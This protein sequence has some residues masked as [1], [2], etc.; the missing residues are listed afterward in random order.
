MEF[1][2]GQ[3]KKKDNFS[4]IIRLFWEIS[5]H[6]SKKFSGIRSLCEGSL[7]HI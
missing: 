6:V 2:L 1:K 5:I 3:R 4:L 7:S